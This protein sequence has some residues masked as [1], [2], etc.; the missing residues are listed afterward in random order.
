MKHARLLWIGL[1][2]LVVAG[3]TA[4]ALVKADH[5]K[6]P[7]AAAASSSACSA[8]QAAACT[9]EMAAACD[10]QHAMAANGAEC[11]MGGASA[12][13]AAANG[14]CPHLKGAVAGAGC[15]PSQCPAGAC[16]PSQCP[17]GMCETMGHAKGVSAVAASAGGACC[18]S[19]ATAGAAKAGDA[20]A[21]HAKGATTAG[22]TVDCDA[23][24]DMAACQSDISEAG[25]KV[26][27]VTLKNGLM[28]MYSADSSP[29]VRAVQAA[30][31]R[32]A[33]R[34]AALSASADKAR[35]CSACREMRG[36][37]A[38]GKLT[39]EVV[40]V[41]TGC[42]MLMTSNDQ[43]VVSRLYALAG[44]SGGASRAVAKS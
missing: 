27:V 20:C 23:C 32:H 12:T 30:V 42:L 7:M 22:M 11:C 21:P 25:G 8:E 40:N 35:L 41:E 10:Q 38:S 43:R 26:Q 39:R 17:P 3:T 16:D 1:A 28:Y 24:A 31:H 5:G 29:R 2:V 14:A 9:P 18:A 33:D 44:V 15:D 36:A 37:A 19:G 13:T 6:H 34:L 4:F